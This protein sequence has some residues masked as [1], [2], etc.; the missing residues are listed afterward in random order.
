[1]PRRDSLRAEKILQDRLFKHPK[2][3]RPIC[4]DSVLDDVHGAESPMKV[5]H[6]KLK[7]VKT[8]AVSEHPADGIFIAIGHVPATELVAGQVEM[9]PSGYVKTAP[10]STAGFRCPDCSPPA[11]SLTRSIGEAVAAA[12]ARL[13]GGTGSP[14]GFSP[15]YASACATQRNEHWLLPVC[16]EKGMRWIEI[17]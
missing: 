13:H 6:A 2:I 16:G 10:H 14:G 4:W 12:G 5:T 8:G 7:N 3:E 1:M 17:N 9:K 11:T 15:G